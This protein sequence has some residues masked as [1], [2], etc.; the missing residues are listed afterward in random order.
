ME[1]LLE[2]TI[3]DYRKEF[4]CYHNSASG[5]TQST[6]ENVFKLYLRKEYKMGFPMSA[7]PRAVFAGGINR[8]GRAREDGGMRK[9]GL[10]PG[11]PLTPAASAGTDRAAIRS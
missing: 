11:D 10:P 1:G 2:Y 5:G 6:Y 4:G 3:P 9:A 8:L 7:R